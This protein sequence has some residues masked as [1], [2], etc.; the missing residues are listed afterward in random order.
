MFT[1]G[2]AVI[3]AVIDLHEEKRVIEMMPRV[4]RVIQGSGNDNSNSGEECKRKDEHSK[5]KH[6]NKKVGVLGRRF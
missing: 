3:K 2:I 6:K 4:L 1:G 5:R